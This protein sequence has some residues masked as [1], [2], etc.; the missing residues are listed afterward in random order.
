MKIEIFTRSMNW[1]LYKL[2]A[3]TILL[4]YKKNRCR[5]TSADGYFYRNILKSSADIVLNI[6]ED[7]FITDNNRLKNILEYFLDNDFVNCG[8]PDGGVM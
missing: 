7:A 8:V 5:F 2:S 6:D 4:P 1:H 3:K